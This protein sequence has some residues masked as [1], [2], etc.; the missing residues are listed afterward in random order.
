MATLKINASTPSARIVEEANR[1]YLEAD[2]K[3]RVI[4][5]HRLGISGHRR[6]LK[7]ISNESANKQQLFSLYLMAA[8]VVSIDGD[9]ITF[10]I[11]ELQLDALVDRLGDDGFAA[12]MQA[13]PA[14]LG[15]QTEEGL[16]EAAGE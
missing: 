15:L 6:L 5:F 14:K 1:T 2:A 8:S 3:G 4:E 9:A 11:N 16:R 7:A 12:L 13:I 10:P